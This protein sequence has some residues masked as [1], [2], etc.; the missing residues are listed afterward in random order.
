MAGT[1]YFDS[2]DLALYL[3]YSHLLLL[4]PKNATF[5]EFHSD[6]VA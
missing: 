5:S 1:E 3:S 2:D 4:D 6:Y